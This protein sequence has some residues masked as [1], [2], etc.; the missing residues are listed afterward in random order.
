MEKSLLAQKHVLFVGNQNRYGVLSNWN[1]K[2]EIRCW[3]DSKDV[4]QRQIETFLKNNMDFKMQSRKHG[5]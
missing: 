4:V 3:V 2:K 5:N 1:M